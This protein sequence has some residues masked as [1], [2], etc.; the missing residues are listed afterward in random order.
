M[1]SAAAP[2]HRSASTSAV[3]QAKVRMMPSLSHTFGRWWAAGGSRQRLP[4][5]PSLPQTRLRGRRPLRLPVWRRLL[6][7]PAHS[8]VAAA[9]AASAAPA[10][11]APTGRPGRA[12]PRRRCSARLRRAAAAPGCDR[13]RT[14]DT[15]GPVQQWGRGVRFGCQGGTCGQR[16]KMGKLHSTTNQCER[17]FFRTGRYICPDGAIP[18]HAGCASQC[19]RAVP[20]RGACGKPAATHS[21][22]PAMP[23]CCAKWLYHPNT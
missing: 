17:T 19:I 15:G 20:S 8:A 5:C 2:P 4:Q 9:A 13:R 11:I 3:K 6:L 23:S 22:T 7:H 18:E 12:A 1:Q 14:S 10:A 21:I 16:G